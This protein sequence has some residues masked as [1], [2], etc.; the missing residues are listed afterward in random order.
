M[1]DDTALAQTGLE[2]LKAAYARFTENKQQYPL[3]YDC[4]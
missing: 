4:E 1:L 2:K 3:V